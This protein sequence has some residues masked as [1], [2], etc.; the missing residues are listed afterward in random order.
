MD[1]EH[2]NNNRGKI[3]PLVEHNGAAYGFWLIGRW[4]NTT[5]GKAYYYGAYPPSYLKRLQLLFPDEFK[6][7]ILHLFSGTVEGDKPRIFT[8]DLNPEPVPGVKPNI[9]ADAEQLDKHVPEG[10]F[11]IVIA[12]PPY[13][14]NHLKYGIKK[15][16]NRKKVVHLCSRV[17]KNGGYLI[18]LDTIIPQ[19][20]KRDGWTLR[21]LIGMGQSTNH[22]VRVITILQ[23]AR[24]DEKGSQSPP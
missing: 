8:L 3:S 13:G 9:V 15:K 4:H 20:A 24:V 11:D 17:L 23:N 12:D 2:Y 16:V 1:I 18:W 10:F 22:R 14:D 6:G 19:W 7:T 21:G 5:K